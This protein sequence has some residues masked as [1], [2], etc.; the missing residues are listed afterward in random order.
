M[1]CGEGTGDGEAP[2]DDRGRAAGK[3]GGMLET[4]G[5]TFE[6]LRVVPGLLTLSSVG[7]GM[8]ADAEAEAEAEDGG[9]AGGG[10]LITGLV[11]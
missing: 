1:G 9:G 3:V 11:G 2:P 5:S 6:G 4:W 10:G 8:G 7:G